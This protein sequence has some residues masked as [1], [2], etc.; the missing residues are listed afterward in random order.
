MMVVVTGRKRTLFL[1][2]F[3]HFYLEFTLGQYTTQ[4][5]QK[6]ISMYTFVYLL[7]VCQPL[8]SNSKAY[9]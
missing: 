1:S 5:A 7:T 3:D 4:K 9:I 8:T 2:L 6:M